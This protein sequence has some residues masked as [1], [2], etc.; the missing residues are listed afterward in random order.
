MPTISTASGGFAQEHLSELARGEAAAIRIQR[1]LEPEHCA[2]FAE[3]LIDQPGWVVHSAVPG[4]EVLGLP[5]YLAARGGEILDRYYTEAQSCADRF[6]QIAA[7]YRSPLDSLCDTLA[8][9]WPSGL[10]VGRLEDGHQMS[11]AT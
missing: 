10:V 11:P 8:R 4:L 6:R 9:I 2:W 1:L 5:F 7:P 3:R